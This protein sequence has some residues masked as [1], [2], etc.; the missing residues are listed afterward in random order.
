M[1]LFSGP[2]SRIET[3]RRNF[4]GTVVLQKEE[5]LGNQTIIYLVLFYRQSK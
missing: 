1:K 4:C 5:F 2:V 3:P